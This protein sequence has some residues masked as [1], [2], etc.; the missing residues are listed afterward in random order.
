MSYRAG[1]IISDELDMVT[2]YT[3]SLHCEDD[4]PDILV[5]HERFYF[6]TGDVVF[7]VDKTIFK[8][9][10]HF[11]SKASPVLGDMLL[12]P[13]PNRRETPLKTPTMTTGTTSETLCVKESQSSTLSEQPLFVLHGDSVNGWEHI[14]SIFYRDEFFGPVVFS[15][16]E[17]AEILPI[18]HKYEM[19]QIETRGIA[20][21]LSGDDVLNSMELLI[22][23]RWIDSKEIYDTAIEALADGP[24]LTG[25]DARRIGFKAFYE[26]KIRRYTGYCLSLTDHDGYSLCQPHALGQAGCTEHLTW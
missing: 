5:R 20:Y 17:W 8:V 23:G 9:H 1:S 25:E 11:L 12:L 7:Q 4:E 19:R 15:A 3:S 2:A 26:V 6:V 24:I 10:S 18:A 21:L 16:T 13:Q 14:L 22:L